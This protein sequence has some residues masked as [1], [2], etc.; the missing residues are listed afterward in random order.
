MPVTQSALTERGVV[1]FVLGEKCLNVG[2]KLFH[3]DFIKCATTH[4]QGVLLSGYRSPNDT[5]DTTHMHDPA[6]ELQKVRAALRRVMAQKGIRN[7]PLAKMAG[8]GE[9]SV[10]DLLDNEDR[11]I[12][13]GTLHKIA[14]ALEIS[15]DDLLG[16][17]A[18]VVVG[19]VGAGGNVIFEE[20]AHGLVPRPPGLGGNL[21]ALEVSGSSMLPRYSSGDIVYI[22]RAHD[23]VNPDDVGEY[24]AVRLTTGETYI[25]QLTYGSRPGFFTL[26]SLNDEDII[27]VEIE[28]ATPIIF[29]LPRAARRRLGF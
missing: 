15:I 11:D 2:E 9:T 19:K 1:H 28:W 3:A 25:K 24:C 14:G 13:L 18:V 22:S 23:G 29:V 6:D 8:L 10:R 4:R 7:K 5:C 21:E 12:K 20:V 16:G 26:R 17:A 27:D